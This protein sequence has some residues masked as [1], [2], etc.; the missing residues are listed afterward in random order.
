MAEISQAL[1]RMLLALDVGSVPDRGHDALEGQGRGQVHHRLS[2]LDQLGGGRP[3]ALGTLV[4]ERSL[5][6][7]DGGAADEKGREQ[8]Q[9]GQSAHW[10]LR[11]TIS[12]AVTSL[13]GGIESCP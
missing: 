1:G 12:G 9:Q 10:N 6:A 3:V 7:G 8:Q 11:K 2:G 13:G 4:E 5:V